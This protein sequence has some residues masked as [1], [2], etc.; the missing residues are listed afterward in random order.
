MSDACGCGHDE[1]R[2]E[3]EE[4]HEPEKLWQITEIRAA[5]AAGVLL[6]AGLIVGWVGGPDPV[7]LALERSR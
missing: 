7:T 2:P 4:E 5:A 1:P 6:T 3:G